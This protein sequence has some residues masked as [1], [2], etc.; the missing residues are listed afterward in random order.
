MRTK[1]DEIMSVKEA[2]NFLGLKKSTI[3]AATSAKTIPHYKSRANNRVFFKKDELE[4]WQLNR[5][6]GDYE[7]LVHIK[8]SEN[9]NN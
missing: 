7:K 9:T 5:E 2:A 1:S 6:I 8:V 4:A 3:Y